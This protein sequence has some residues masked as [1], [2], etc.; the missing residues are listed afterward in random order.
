MPT[1]TLTRKEIAEQSFDC[2]IQIV[3]SQGGLPKNNEEGLVKVMKH[4]KRLALS[5]IGRERTDG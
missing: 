1:D 3:K 5:N 2:C 4:F